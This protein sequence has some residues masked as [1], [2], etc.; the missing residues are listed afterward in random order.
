MI[1][2]V[3]PR[4]QK[5]IVPES[6]GSRPPHP[7]P[8][9][10]YNEFRFSTMLLCIYLRNHAKQ[11]QFDLSQRERSGAMCVLKS[12]P[13]RNPFTHFSFCTLSM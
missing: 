1:G 3:S 12:L 13:L 6:H 8:S 7:A 2:A 4:L 11:T 9:P 5:Q 10:Q